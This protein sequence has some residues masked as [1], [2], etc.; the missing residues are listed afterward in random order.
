MHFCSGNHIWFWHYTFRGP[1]TNWNLFSKWPR[2]QRNTKP[3]YMKNSW[4]KSGDSAQRREDEPGSVIATVLRA[5]E[6]HHRQECIMF[7]PLEP[8]R[9]RALVGETQQGYLKEAVTRQGHAKM[10]CMLNCGLELTDRGQ[11][12]V[13][14]LFPWAFQALPIASNPFFLISLLTVYDIHAHWCKRNHDFGLWVSDHC[15]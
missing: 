11:Q 4:R 2:W 9:T 13:T 8:S 1:L 3:R 14:A 15:K 12:S 7:C 10:K 5:W 6:R